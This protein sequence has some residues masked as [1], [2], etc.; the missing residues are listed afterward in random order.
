MLIGPGPH[1]RIGNIRH[2]LLIWTLLLGRTGS[3]RKGEATAISELFM[4]QARPEFGD[5]TVGGLSS[6]EGLIERIRDGV[7][8]DKRLLV[9]EPEFTAVM[10][11]SRR[12]GSTLATVQRQAWEGR[13]LSVLNRKEFGASSSHVAVIGHVA[14]R[15][16]R[17]RLAETDMAGGTYNRY[18]PVY[19]ERAKLLPIPEGLHEQLIAAQAGKLAAAIGRAAKVGAVQ[20]GRDATD[21]WTGEL[22]PEFAG[23]DDDD[24]R[25]YS[26]FTRRAAPYCLRIGGLYAALDGRALIGKDD[27][28]AAGALVRYSL[29]SARYVLGSAHRD[30]RMDRLTRAL[31]AAGEAGLTLTAISALFSRNLPAAVLAE[32]L[33]ELLASRSYEEI[34]AQTGGRAATLYRRTSFV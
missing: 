13:A 33:G 12:E 11:R 17:L 1:V 20:L 15:E 9:I 31:T 30:P 26:E 24:D 3:G 16:F 34:Q 21:L 6:G 2:P 27:L 19:V 7:R 18:L 8:D 32:L 29:A 25:A 28:A 10:A 5:L 4:R 14:P 22:Y 23:A